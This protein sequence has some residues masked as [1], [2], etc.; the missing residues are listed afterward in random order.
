M[1]RL[2]SSLASCAT[3]PSSGFFFSIPWTHV[4]QFTAVQRPCRDSSTGKNS[5]FLALGCREVATGQPTRSAL[6]VFAALLVFELQLIY[7]YLLRR[8]SGMEQV[9]GTLA[10][11]LPSSFEEVQGL[12]WG[13]AADKRHRKRSGFFFSPEEPQPRSL[14]LHD[15]VTISRCLVTN[16]FLV[17]FAC[18]SFTAILPPTFDL[19]GSPRGLASA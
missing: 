19:T 13:L 14:A 1:D 6:R 16:V 5:P 10:D 3:C 12:G 7:Q 11:R 15:L 8:V 4:F 17:C 2:G 9:P 18:S